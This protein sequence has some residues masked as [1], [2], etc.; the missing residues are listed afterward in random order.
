MGDYNKS[1]EKRWFQEMICEDGKCY[2]PKVWL[3]SKL[4]SFFGKKIN[5]KELIDDIETKGILLTDQSSAKTKKMG[6]HRYYVID[7][8]RLKNSVQ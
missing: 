4:E 5:L 2:I 3:Q 7:I 6:G 1:S 8:W